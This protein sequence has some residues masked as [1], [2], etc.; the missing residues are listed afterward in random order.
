MIYIGNNEISNIYVGTD[1]IIG[2]YAGDLQIYPTDFGNVTAI[3]LENLEWV[4]DVPKSGGT[5]DSGNCSFD[6]YAL[7]DSGKRRKVNKD[8]V[9][10]GS[11]VVPATTATTRE[12]VGTLTLTASYSGFTD[13]DSVDAYQSTE[14]EK[15]NLAFSILTDGEIKW[16]CTSNSIAKTISYNKNY[17]GWNVISPTIQGTSISVNA[18]DYV[19]FRG[20]NIKY[21]DRLDSSSRNYF[22]TTCNFNLQGNIMSLINSTNFSTLTAFTE[23]STN[24]FDRMFQNCTGL[25]SAE[26]LVLPAVRLGQETYFAMFQG[27]TSLTTAPKQIGAENTTWMFTSTYNYT[28]RSM[29]S[30]CTSLTTAPALPATAVNYTCYEQMFRDCTSLTTAPELP[31]PT[32]AGYCYNQMFYNCSSLNYVKC[33]ATNI[34]ASYCTNSWLNNVASTGTF[35]K[36]PNMS[37]WSTGASGIPNNWTITDNT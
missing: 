27:C 22:S 29:F 8:A 14:Y 18:G 16:C 9:V 31:A 26:N 15:I 23:G 5:A 28:C 20:D 4:K 6:V 7:Y 32:L 36:N 13:S 17:A 10:T 30:G 11:L 3:T 1:E 35:I 12:M 24:H 25:I 2:I 19:Q 33:L 37:G 21:G 34:S